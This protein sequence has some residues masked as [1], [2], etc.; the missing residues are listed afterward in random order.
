MV[1]A[2][3]VLSRSPWARDSVAPPSTP[4]RAIASAARRRAKRVGP[5]F[6]G[7]VLEGFRLGGVQ[8]GEAGNSRP[9][10]NTPTVKRQC[11]I[12]RLARHFHG[13][14]NSGSRSGPRIDHNT[15]T[16]NDLSAHCKIGNWVREVS[17]I[18][19]GRTGR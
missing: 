9:K 4:T 19:Q 6:T 2:H 11:F 5:R 1:V 18:H 16:Y 10:T 12:G 15:M 8:A 13:K 14:V 17:G 3:G 7:P